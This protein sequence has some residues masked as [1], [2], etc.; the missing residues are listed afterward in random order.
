MGRKDVVILSGAPKGEKNLLRSLFDPHSKTYF[1]PEIPKD[2]FDEYAEERGKKRHDVK[3]AILD[4]GVMFNHPWIKP[5]LEKSVDFTGEGPEDEVGHGT[6]C[7]LLLLGGI[8]PYIRLLNIKVVGADSRGSEQDLIKGID[9]AISEGACIISISIGVYRKRWGL[10]ECKGDCGVCKAVEKAARAKIMVFIS[11]GNEPGRT[12]CPAKITVMKPE[13]M[14]LGAISV[15]ASD[16][17]THNIASY[18][19]IGNI[20]GGP[21]GYRLIPLENKLEGTYGVTTGGIQFDTE[22]EAWYHKG[23]ALTKQGNYEE[24]LKAYDEAIRINPKIAELWNNKGV[25][26]KKQGKFQGA[27]D[28]FEEAIKTN[29]QYINAWNNKGNALSKQGRYSEAIQAYNEAIKVDP[30]HEAAWYNK[31]IAFGIWGKNNEAFTCF[32]K[33]IE[34]NPQHADAWYNKGLVLGKQDKPEAA[35]K[36]FSKAIEIDPQHSYA[37]YNKSIA[38]KILGRNLEAHEAAAK[39][40]ALVDKDYSA[41]PDDR[42]VYSDH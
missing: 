1:V 7:A 41:A 32:N 26:L 16:P 22:L 40:M 36:C 28:S 25:I 9:W 31:G 30:R 20:K 37:W 12:Y 38:L 8:K 18:S 15:M 39:A 6:L 10:F 4:T 33:V 27:V 21:G 23:I 5:S 42:V 17:I 29:S 2:E 35:V 3:V 24:A 14:R 19:G 11:P 34:V 13:V